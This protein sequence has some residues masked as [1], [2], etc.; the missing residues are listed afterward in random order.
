[1]M[2]TRRSGVV[3]YHQDLVFLVGTLLRLDVLSKRNILV[4]YGCY[5]CGKDESILYPF[6]ECPPVST[7]AFNIIGIRW[8]NWVCRSP[9]D[10]IR[11]VLDWDHIFLSKVLD[12]LLTC[13]VI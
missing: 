7:L 2:A 5:F 1:M 3:D 6:W 13:L 11:N 12:V 8:E 10:L 4:E 9:T